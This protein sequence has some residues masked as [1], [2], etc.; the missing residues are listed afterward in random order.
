[1][2]SSADQILGEILDLQTG[3]KSKRKHTN[4]GKKN[5]RKSGNKGKSKNKNKKHS[6]KK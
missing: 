5:T 4:K 3:G 6:K 2:S 1:M